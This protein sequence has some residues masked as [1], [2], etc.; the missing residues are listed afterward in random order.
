MK[1]LHEE[2]GYS[3]SIW[4]LMIPRQ[5]HHKH[6]VPYNLYDIWTPICYVNKV[7]NRCTWRIR[8][9]NSRSEN[10]S[11]IC[12]GVIG[13]HCVRWWRAVAYS[14][15]SHHQSQWWSIVQGSSRT[16]LSKIWIQ[17]H[18]L[19]LKKKYLKM[20]SEKCSGLSAL[21][22]DYKF[23]RYLSSRWTPPEILCRWHYVLNGHRI[24]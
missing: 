6:A 23:I 22:R 4:W 16:N 20:A 14:G 24:R 3:L 5:S 18:N 2:N 21:A 8:D 12:V 10:Y 7:S 11:A 17:T 9:R 19:S 1:L 15:P 13:H